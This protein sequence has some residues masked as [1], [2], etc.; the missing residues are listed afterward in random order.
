MKI[1]DR[2]KLIRNYWLIKLPSLNYLV[3]QELYLIGRQDE[4]NHR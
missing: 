3:S 1:N 4:M 2:L